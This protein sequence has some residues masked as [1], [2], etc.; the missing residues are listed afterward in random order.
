MQ[1]HFINSPYSKYFLAPVFSSASCFCFINYLLIFTLP[2]L[3]FFS[4]K[5]KKKKKTLLKKKKNYL[6]FW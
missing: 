2:F 5:G 3:F 1:I 6:D 4:S